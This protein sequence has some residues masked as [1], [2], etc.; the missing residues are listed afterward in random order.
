M[1]SSLLKQEDSLQEAQGQLRQVPQDVL[2]I[3]GQG[4]K[5]AIIGTETGSKTVHTYRQDAACETCGSCAQAP[6]GETKA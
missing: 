2:E 5:E 3:R 4:D 1:L 6:E